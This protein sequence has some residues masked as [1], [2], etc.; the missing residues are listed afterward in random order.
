MR[1][2]TLFICSLTLLASCLKDDAVGY[3]SD[4]PD[5]FMTQIDISYEA[6]R[7]VTVAHV[8]FADVSDPYQWKGLQLPSNSHIKMN[9]IELTWHPES[10]FYSTEFDGTPECFVEFKNHDETI[11]NFNLFPPDTVYFKNLPDTI[12]SLQE[13]E[14]H[15]NAPILDSNERDRICLDVA[16]G[17]NNNCIYNGQDSIINLESQHFQPEKTHIMYLYRT[18][19]MLNPNLPLGGG[20]VTYNYIIEQL[21]FSE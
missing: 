17:D 12:P 3:T 2:L 14:L 19:N 15:V 21:I 20:G 8:F 9:G 1:N 4:I 13:F 10:R 7:K 16:T 11:Y 6:S 5:E 18:K